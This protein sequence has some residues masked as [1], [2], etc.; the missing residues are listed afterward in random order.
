ML[1]G[2]ASVSAQ[3]IGPSAPA[4]SAP[5]PHLQTASRDEGLT[6]AAIAPFQWGSIGARPHAEYRLTRSSGIQYRPGQPVTT[7]VSTLS[8]GSSFSLGQRWSADYTP[9]WTMYSNPALSDTVDHAAMISGFASFT[10]GTLSFAQTYALSDSPRIETGRQTREETFSTSLSGSYALT[11]RIRVDVSLSRSARSLDVASDSVDWSQQTWLH[12]QF[13]ERLDVAAGVGAGYVSI[14]PGT[15]MSYVRPQVRLGWKPTSKLGFDVHGG[16][17]QRRFRSAGAGE[18]NSPFYGASGF[19]QPFQYTTF[20]IG[21]NRGISPSYFPGQVNENTSWTLGF[22]QRLF[23]HFNFNAS[24]S[25][26]SSD[27]LSVT[28][29]GVAVT[30]EDE[31]R[32]YNLRLGT[33]FLRRGTVGIVYQHTENKSDATAFSFSSNQVGLEMS[34]RY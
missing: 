16:S 28:A 20:S 10:D 13:S 17:D 29:N 1:V 6:D 9:T 21:G 3:A 24:T 4:P 12:Y 32:S 31:S 14:D 33:S 2:A 34:Y 7:T 15:D 11:T 18:L 8:V 26:M 25:R 19:Y 5:P 23:K 22:S 30:R 27:Y